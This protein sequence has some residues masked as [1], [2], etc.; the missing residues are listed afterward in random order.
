VPGSYFE[1]YI[2][3]I[4]AVK[5]RE[6]WLTTDIEQSVMDII[7]MKAESQR[8][9][10]IAIGNTIDHIHVLVSIHPDTVIST[11]LK[12]MKT[13]SSYFVNH[14]LEKV[15]YWQDGYGALSVSKKGLEKVHDYVENQK[16]HHARKTILELFETINR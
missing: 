14:N 3:L 12:E 15:L 7:K 11:M 10:V 16:T 9:K 5:N 13:A 4:W 6:P 2:H 8:A 1:L